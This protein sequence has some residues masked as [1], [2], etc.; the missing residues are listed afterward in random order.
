MGGAPTIGAA[1][2]I[3][4]CPTAMPMPKASMQSDDS[5]AM[6][7]RQPP[8]WAATRSEPRGNHHCHPTTITI[9]AMKM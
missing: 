4:S 8:R 5:T 1:I 2:A 7:S 3:A 6:A 9:H